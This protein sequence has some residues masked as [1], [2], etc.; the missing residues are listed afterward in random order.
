MPCRAHD[1]SGWKPTT[2]RWKRALPFKQKPEIIQREHAG[3]VVF[4][5]DV[6]G[7]GALLLLKLSNFFFDALLHEQTV[8]DH[9]ARLADAMGAVDGLGFDGGIP[10]RIVEHDVARRGEVETEP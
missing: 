10:P 9:V 5:E 6:F 3:E 7:K 4:T 2:A 8:G 1:V